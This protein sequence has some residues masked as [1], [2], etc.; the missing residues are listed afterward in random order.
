[1]SVI[2]FDHAFFSQIN[3]DL[4]HVRGTPACRTGRFDPIFSLTPK[5]R[6]FTLP[7]FENDEDKC[8]TALI[9]G[10]VFRLYL[11]NHM[12]YLHTYAKPK[13][14]QYIID[15]PQDWSAN[16]CLPVR[17]VPRT[18]PALLNDL[19]SLDYNLTTNGGNRFLGTADDER[20]ASVIHALEH[21]L[22]YAACEDRKTQTH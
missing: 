18:T 1:M 13:D 15:L 16:A 5:D 17:Q 6:I 10:F 19:W 4:T 7:L 12:A 21:A 2:A 11:A 9:E 8:R 22:A 3:A 20:L 14:M